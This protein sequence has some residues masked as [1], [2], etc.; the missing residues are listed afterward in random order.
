ML[1]R[2]SVIGADNLRRRRGFCGIFV[3]VDVLGESL[4]MRVIE[5]YAK[6]PSSNRDEPRKVR[7]LDQFTSSR[8]L[9]FE[10][11]KS[12]SNTGWTRSKQDQR[13]GYQLWATSSCTSGT[14]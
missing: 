3:G 14:E 9:H 12:L 7:T 11:V 6:A 5:E 4:K 1:R 10:G 13:R 2:R 8:N